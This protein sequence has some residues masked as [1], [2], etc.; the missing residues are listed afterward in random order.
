MGPETAPRRSRLPPRLTATLGADGDTM[1]GRW[2]QSPD[3]EQWTTGFDVT[4][5]RTARTAKPQG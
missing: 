4:F 3:G 5:V 1:E 2:E